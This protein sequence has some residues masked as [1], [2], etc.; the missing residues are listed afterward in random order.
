MLFNRSEE[1]MSMK[2]KKNKVHKENKISKEKIKP[3]FSKVF[4]KVN[5]NKF[6]REIIN[7]EN[8]LFTDLSNLQ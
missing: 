6:L 2:K 3:E 5:K 8:Q 1:K 4:L 7:N